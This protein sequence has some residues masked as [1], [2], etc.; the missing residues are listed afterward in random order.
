LVVSDAGQEEHVKQAAGAARA[1]VAFRTRH[2]RRG[3]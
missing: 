2:Y 3:I 1:G